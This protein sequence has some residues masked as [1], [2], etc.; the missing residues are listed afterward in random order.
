MREMER[1]PNSNT[2]L[3]LIRMWRSEHPDRASSPEWERLAANTKKT[4][5]SALNKFGEKWGSVPLAVF[6]D[7]RMT[8]E[9]IAWRNSRRDTPRAADN[10]ITVLQAL[11]KFGMQ[12]ALRSRDVANEITKLYENGQRAD[13]VWTEDDLNAFEAAAEPDDRPVVDAISLDAA[14]GLRRDDLAWLTWASVREFTLVKETAKRSG[15]KRRFATIPRIPAL[16]AV[17]ADL[18]NRHRDPGVET[19]SVTRSRQPWNLDTLTHE[20]TRI[21]EKA[22]VVHIDVPEKDKPPRTRRKHLHDVRGTFVTRL[23]T[24]TDLTDEEIADIMAWSPAD[25]RRIRTIYVDDHPRSVA[26]GRRIARGL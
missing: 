13:I 19:I 8:Q 5:G 14:T 9:V 6:D 3:S 2:L 17:L 11:L 1:A 10:G 20:V 15:G 4:W 12:N 24:T 16:D 7:P 18:R 22:G 23:M 26:L 25:V 21:V